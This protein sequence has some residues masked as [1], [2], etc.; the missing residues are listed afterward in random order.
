MNLSIAA[1][2][3]SVIFIVVIL[4]IFFAVVFGFYTYRGSGINAHPSDGLDG[5]PG[6]E[7]PSDASGKGRVSEETDE[8]LN[9]GGGFS[10]RGTR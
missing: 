3:G 2:G 9:A 4:V 10:T 6:A 8:E 7:G 5:A 1:A